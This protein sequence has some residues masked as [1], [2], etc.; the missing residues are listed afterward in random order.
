MSKF[1]AGDLAMIISS[2]AEQN[3]GKV[4]RLVECHGNG[5]VSFGGRFYFPG[6]I[7]WTV[8]AEDGSACLAIPRSEGVFDRA[9]FGIC[10]EFRLMPLRKDFHPEQR[11]AKWV[12]A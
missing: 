4:V 7:R 8:E 9:S 1:K 2:Y 12:E 10:S 3:F 11:K 5:G 6:P